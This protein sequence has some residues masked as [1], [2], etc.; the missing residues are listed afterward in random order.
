MTKRKRKKKSAIDTTIWTVNIRCPTEIFDWLLPE[1][2]FHRVP[3]GHLLS[4][5]LL[6]ELRNLEN[7]QSL[8][9]LK[10]HTDLD[11][12]YQETIESLISKGFRLDR[13]PRLRPASPA[14]LPQ[15]R[16][17][18]RLVD[19]LEPA[20]A[21]PPEP[22]PAPEPLSEFEQRR[23]VQVAEKLA[24]SDQE[25]PGD[26]SEPSAGELVQLRAQEGDVTLEEVCD[27]VRYPGD[28]LTADVLEA[29]SKYRSKSEQIQPPFH[30]VPEFEEARRER[31]KVLRSWLE[32]YVKLA[33]EGS[34]LR[35]Q[36]LGLEGRQKRQLGVRAR[37][38]I[39]ELKKLER[40]IRLSQRP[41]LQLLFEHA[42][43][44]ASVG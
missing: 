7:I 30:L 41:L 6:K 24:A 31:G 11:R 38:K 23:Q 21:P 44:A 19:G 34:Q 1:L 29:Y 13:P 36:A 17:P 2:R 43:A 18:L 22:E 3:Q 37:S 14:P 15:R 26:K 12:L 27:K 40:S 9:D 25:P 33:V 32:L 35:Q 16:P 39:R 5:L 10:T 28:F 42:A 20:A 4:V 8:I